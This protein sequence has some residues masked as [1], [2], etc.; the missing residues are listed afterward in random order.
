MAG[1]P[2]NGGS[3]TPVII[4]TMVQ[5]ASDIMD[6]W[7]NMTC[8]YDPWHTVDSDKVTLPICMFHVKKIVPARTVEVSKKRVILYEPQNDGK[9]YA[10][11]IRTGVMQTIVDNAVKQPV[12]Y[13][14][15]IIVP[16]QPTGKYFT[17]GVKFFQDLLHGFREFFS[18][19]NDTADSAWSGVDS[20]FS[21]ATAAVHTANQA[22]NML[23]KLPGMGGSSH[24]NVNSLE[25]MS[26]SC[27]TL[28]MKMW[29]GLEYKFVMITGMTYDKQ[30]VEDDVVRA[31]LNLQE[32][33]VLEVFRT[34]LKSVDSRKKSVFV[35][36]LSKVYK[37]LSTPLIKM[38]GVEELGSVVTVAKNITLSA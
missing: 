8:L 7:M 1:G 12:T 20:I 16:F 15:E 36:E 32:V 2:I 35:R 34:E 4:P 24:I 6:Y 26:D 17:M 25:A 21:L 22:A 31:T 9:D 30:P 10:N 11:T 3:F 23:A 18:G 37:S 27:R 38:A 13:T 14:M 19:K 28:C 5:M 29:T 33:P